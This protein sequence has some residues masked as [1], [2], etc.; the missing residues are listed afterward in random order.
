[1]QQ[2]AAT[3]EDFVTSTPHGGAAHHPPSPLIDDR[4][5]AI[6][7]RLEGLKPSDKKD[8]WDKFE[9]FSSVL[10]PVI[11]LLVSLFITGRI[12]NALKE[13]ELHLEN[14]KDMQELMQALDKADAGRAMSDALA[15]G[16]HG[17]YAVAPMIQVLQAGVVDHRAAAVAGLRAAAA[18]DVAF[19]C[20]QLTGVIE[21][22]TR[23]YQLEVPESAT[24]LLGDLNCTSAIPALQRYVVRLGRSTPA[25]A[26]FTQVP[27]SQSL[28]Q[29]NIDGVKAQAEA[30][31]K[32][33][34]AARD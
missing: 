33:L 32:A 6:E 18:I 16:A 14:V 30:S 19:V 12:E 26:P 21:N 20:Q 24:Q 22:R 29:A 1:L 2:V 11:T 4:L 17:R 5:A 31:L 8:G 9:K 7:K 34:T 23:L 15:L 25:D 27:G 3:L 28:T 13:R 10:W